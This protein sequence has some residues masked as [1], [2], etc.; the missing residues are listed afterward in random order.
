MRLAAKAIAKARDG[1]QCD[2]RKLGR[3]LKG[4]KTRESR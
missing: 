3:K 1:R 2:S 4:T